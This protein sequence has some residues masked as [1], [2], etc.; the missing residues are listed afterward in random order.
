MDQGCEAL[1]DLSSKSCYPIAS[2][3]PQGLIFVI[4]YTESLGGHSFTKV[5]LYDVNKYEDGCFENWK[6][7]CPEIKI[8][9]FSSS[10]NLI[11][12]ATSEN[13]ILVFDAY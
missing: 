12:C 6:Y 11:L 8:I 10:G 2:F 7:D 1:L 9:K 4:A 13:Y 3:D 5:A